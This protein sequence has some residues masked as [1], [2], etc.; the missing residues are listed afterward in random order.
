MKIRT[1]ISLWITAAGVLVS[2]FFSLFVFREMLEQL[3]RQLDDEIKTATGEVMRLFESSNQPEEQFQQQ[4]TELLFNNR[5]YW[6]RVYEG[7]KLIYASRLARLIDLPM[8]PERKKSTLRVQVSSRMIDLDQGESENVTFRT[9]RTRLAA[10]GD[11]PARLIQVALPMEKLDEEIREVVI[12]ITIG[13]SLSTVLLL[14][15]SYLLAGRI[16]KP[17]RRITELAREIDEQAL[18]ARLPLNHNQDELFELSRAFNQMLDRLQYSFNHQKEFLANAAHELNTPLTTIRLFVEQGME[19]RELPAAFRRR[20][21]AQQ[22]TL[23]RLGRLLRDLMFLSRL[24]IKQQLKSEV[25]DLGEMLTSVLAEFEPLIDLEAMSL[26][27]D[28]TRPAPFRGD[29]D[30]LQRLFINLLDNAIKYCRPPGHLNVRLSRDRDGFKLRLAN[31]SPPLSPEE[32]AQLFEQFYRVEK[33]R[34]AASGGFG[35]GLTIVREI[36]NQHQGEVSINNRND[37]IE[38]LVRLPGRSSG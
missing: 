33:S 34:S 25:F 36:V 2:L 24:E 8:A 12:F 11:Q 7:E 13:L 9:R 27:L 15:I 37:Q 18:T 38:V 21:G 14:L 19:N 5:R 17:I 10:A 4:A 22:Q 26:S 31:S 1:R 3:Y 35:L 29:P 20:L 30:K 16:L 23:Q 6:I 32:L 28:I